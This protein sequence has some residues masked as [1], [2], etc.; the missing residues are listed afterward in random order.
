MRYL[1]L[2]KYTTFTVGKVYEQS[3]NPG[4]YFELYL[5]DNQNYPCGVYKNDFIKIHS[6]I[7]NSW[8]RLKNSCI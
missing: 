7:P 4:S 6:F 2:K 3:S 1:C 8:I 5:T